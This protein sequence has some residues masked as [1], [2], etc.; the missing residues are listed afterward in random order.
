[1]TNSDQSQ[2]INII[3]LWSWELIFYS[4]RTFYPHLDSFC[5][6]SSS[7]HFG[8]IS[9]LP[10][11]RWLTATLDKQTNL[12]DFRTTAVW[13]ILILPLISY[14]SCV[15]S[16]LECELIFIYCGFFVLILV[17]FFIFFVLF[18]SFTTFRPNFTSGLLQ[19]IY[20]NLGLEC[21]VL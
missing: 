17:G 9:P 20:R 18:S 12:A 10:F 14:L 2:S 11:F 13:I 7:L 1:M 3:F 6:V 19:V 16:R 15:F 5:V 21:W 4:L 8:Q